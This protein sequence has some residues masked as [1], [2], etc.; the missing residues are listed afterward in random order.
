MTEA[1]ETGEAAS[2]DDVDVL[3][4]RQSRVECDT[5][6]SNTVERKYICVSNREP[7]LADLLQQ[8]SCCEDKQSFVGVQFEM[9]G[10][11]PQTDVVSATQES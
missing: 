9:F 2:G 8:P 3:L 11:R 1:G 4:H 5:E 6:V 10:C 7:D